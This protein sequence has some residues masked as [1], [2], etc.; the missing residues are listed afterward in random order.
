M[1]LKGKHDLVGVAPGGR[2]RERGQRCSGDLSGWLESEMQDGRMTNG[3]EACTLCFRKVRRSES[4]SME[5]GRGRFFIFGGREVGER[6]V[7]ACRRIFLF[8]CLGE[9]EDLG[10]L[11]SWMDGDA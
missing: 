11:E 6:R 5:S 9:V 10:I 7:R 8:L 3:S 4:Q 1:E 2:S